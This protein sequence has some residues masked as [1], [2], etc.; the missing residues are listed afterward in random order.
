MAPSIVLQRSSSIG[1]S[2]T[3]RLDS[4]RNTA[5]RCGTPSGSSGFSHRRRSFSVATSSTAAGVSVTSNSSSSSSSTH[6]FLGSGYSF[7]G[8]SRR[9]LSDLAFSA[10]NHRHEKVHDNSR[11]SCVR[12]AASIDEAAHE[13]YSHRHFA[14][15]WQ[16]QAESQPGA[17]LATPVETEAAESVHS[18]GVAVVSSEVSG[19][20]ASA[21]LSQALLSRSA[22]RTVASVGVSAMSAARLRPSML[23]RSKG[24]VVMA[25]ALA[26]AGI[27]TMIRSHDHQ[28]HLEYDGGSEGEECDECGGYGLCCCSLCGGTG[29]IRWE[30]KYDRKDPCPA[31]VGEGC[32]KCPKCGSSRRNKAVPPIVLE[33]RVF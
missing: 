29:A 25:V 31:C 5:C 19:L 32:A 24:G 6:R 22:T 7:G 17:Q 8:T 10:S 21:S 12:C 16:R 2:S 27:V 15:S 26:V 23:L 1:N 14:A 9:S 4:G 30:G 20:A 18:A 13:H 11:G 3:F 28:H 33:R